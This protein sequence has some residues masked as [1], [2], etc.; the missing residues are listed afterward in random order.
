MSF[1]KVSLHCTRSFLKEKEGQEK[2]SVPIYFY[3]SYFAICDQTDGDFEK[4]I[5]QAVDLYLTMSYLAESQIY[6]II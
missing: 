6:V 1:S 5:S 2:I 3:M 4:K